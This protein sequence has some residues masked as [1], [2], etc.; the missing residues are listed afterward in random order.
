M[1]T[2]VE[3]DPE[4]QSAD[5]R[6]QTPVEPALTFDLQNCKLINLFQAAKYVVICYTA[7]E[8]QMRAPHSLPLP[9]GARAAGTQ[10]DRTVLAFILLVN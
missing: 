10:V 9:L 6:V 4:T 2:P 8:K 1:Q 5:P 7:I 3:P